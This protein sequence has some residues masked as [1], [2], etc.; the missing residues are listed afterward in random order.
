[1]SLFSQHTVEII[2][3]IER[4]KVVRFLPYI[5]WMPGKFG[6]L[7][8]IIIV[9]DSSCRTIYNTTII[10]FRSDDNFMKNLFNVDYILGVKNSMLNL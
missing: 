1:M 5:N 10:K 8:G 7:Q 6:T 3:S 9:H 4:I 2:F